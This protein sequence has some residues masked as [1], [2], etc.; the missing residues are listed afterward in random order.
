M[1]ADVKARPCGDMLKWLRDFRH[2]DVEEVAKAHEVSAA[3][4]KAVGAMVASHVDGIEGKRPGGNAWPSW[5][6]LSQY[7]G[8]DRRTAGRALEALIESRWLIRTKP[9]ARKSIYQLS[10][11]ENGAPQPAPVPPSEPEG[12]RSKADIHEDLDDIR[13][14]LNS[15]SDDVRRKLRQQVVDAIPEDQRKWTHEALIERR[16]WA[17]WI[18]GEDYWT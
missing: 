16:M 10:V 13:S 18:D 9:H 7:V 8:V 14:Q 5:T 3:T 11:P 17:L 15:L 6:T 2:A 12:E 1:G 4:V